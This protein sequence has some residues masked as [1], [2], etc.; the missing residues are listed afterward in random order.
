M[1]LKE[2]MRLQTGQLVRYRPTG[3]VG[4]VVT[5]HLGATD[6]KSNKGGRV[7]MGWRPRLKFVRV[8]YHHVDPFWRRPMDH[9]PRSLSS[10]KDGVH[11][12]KIDLLEVI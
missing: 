7:Y 2:A 4:E 3:E 6:V 11:G 1:T 12:R 5:V 8:S 10:M 9:F